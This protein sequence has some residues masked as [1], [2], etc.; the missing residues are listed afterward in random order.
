MLQ[1]LR[2]VLATLLFTTIICQPKCSSSGMPHELP[3]LLS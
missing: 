1:M 2:V 3:A